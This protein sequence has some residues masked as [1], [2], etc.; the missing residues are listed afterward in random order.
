M[1]ITRKFSG[2]GIA[3]DLATLALPSGVGWVKG[4]PSLDETSRDLTDAVSHGINLL[5]GGGGLFGSWGSN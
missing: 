1:V 2:P 4:L 5:I 3:L